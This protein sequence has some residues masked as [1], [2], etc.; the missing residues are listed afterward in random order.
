MTPAAHVDTITMTMMLMLSVSRCSQTGERAS[1][2]QTQSQSQSQY[3]AAGKTRA[4]HSMIFTRR[5]SEWYHCC[6]ARTGSS[7]SSIVCVV[8][9]ESVQCSAV[10]SCLAPQL[11]HQAPPAAHRYI[12]TV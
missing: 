11:R 1:Q 5:R 6:K 12:H 7:S 2:T 9:L 3:A 4:R 8:P 10:L